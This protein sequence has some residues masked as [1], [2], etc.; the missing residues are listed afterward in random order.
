M[1]LAEEADRIGRSWEGLDWRTS[2]MGPDAPGQY[3]MLAEL[4]W[5]LERE[6]VNVNIT[7]PITADDLRVLPNVSATRARWKQFRD[8]VVTELRK[9]P[10]PPTKVEE[11]W[12]PEVRNHESL[13]VRVEWPR[14]PGWEGAHWPAISDALEPPKESWHELILSPQAPWMDQDA[15]FL[16]VGV[17]LRKLPDWPEDMDDD[18]SRLRE[19]IQ[20]AGGWLGFTEREKIYR[21]LMPRRLEEIIP[22]EKALQAQAEEAVTSALDALQRLLALEPAT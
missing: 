10:T 11:R 5:Y 21:V 6:T 19:A 15:P 4:L 3:L 16:A 22:P 9:N 13:A 17:G 2:A 12:D 18:W 1:E 20:G 7:R 8:L 14:G